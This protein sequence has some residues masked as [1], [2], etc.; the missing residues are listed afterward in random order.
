MMQ[1]MKLGRLGRE[2]IGVVRVRRRKS[3][4]DFQCLKKRRTRKGRKR[5]IWGGDET[6]RRRRKENEI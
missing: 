3:E 2:G 1:G 5:R 6:R 4:R